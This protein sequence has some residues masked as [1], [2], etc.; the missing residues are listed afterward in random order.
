M[1]VVAFILAIL[2]A[3]AFLLAEYGPPVNP[4]R[5]RLAT[6]GV[7]LAL[8]TAAWCVQLIWAT[9]PTLRAGGH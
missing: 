8:L 5:S 9:G 2:A 3:V 7:G 1:N 4:P 6:L